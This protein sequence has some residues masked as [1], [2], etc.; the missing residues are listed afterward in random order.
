MVTE[1]WVSLE[2]TVFYRITVYNVRVKYR[3]MQGDEII[4]MKIF[5][6]KIVAWVWRGRMKTNCVD[7]DNYTISSSCALRRNTQISNTFLF[8]SQLF[9]N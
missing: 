3:K 5:N 8:A 2:G 4:T 9:K 7:I 1:E 6:Q